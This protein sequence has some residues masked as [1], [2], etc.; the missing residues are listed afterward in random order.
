MIPMTFTDICREITEFIQD[1]SPKVLSVIKAEINKEYERVA[2]SSYWRELRAF[3]NEVITFTAG[4]AYLALPSDCAFVQYVGNKADDYTLRNMTLEAMSEDFLDQIDDSGTPYRW[5]ELGESAIRAPLSA[6]DEIEVLSSSTSDTNQ[7]I[8]ITGLKNSPEI[9]RV[10]ELTLNGTTVVTGAIT[11][12]QG[13]S[14]HSITSDDLTIG[15]VT[16]RQESTDV[17][18]AHM[19]PG[20]KV[21]SYFMIRVEN[22]PDSADALLVIYKRKIRPLVNN[23]DAPSIPV[24]K[25]LVEAVIRKMRQYDRKYDE[26]RD[27]DRQARDIMGAILS[28]RGMQSKRSRQIRPDFSGRLLRRE[29]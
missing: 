26:A 1:D 2:M 18:L 27:H 3:K 8:R 11:W 12:Q 5:A 9:I 15:E 22:P 29:F 7:M 16:I 24:G 20:D 4:Q 25:Y 6:A 10:E 17:S 23:D 13:F 14:I 19:A 28:E 21:T